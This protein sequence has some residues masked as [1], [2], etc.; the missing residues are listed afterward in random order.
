MCFNG[1]LSHPRGYNISMRQWLWHSL[2]RKRQAH[3][4]CRCCVLISWLFMTA[5]ADNNKYCPALLYTTKETSEGE[6]RV[7]LFREEASLRAGKNNFLP[8]LFCWN[9]NG[10]PSSKK[11]E[12][13]TLFSKSER[14]SVIRVVLRARKKTFHVYFTFRLGENHPQDYLKRRFHG[15]FRGKKT[16]R[17]HKGINPNLPHFFST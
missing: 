13:A 5:K 1:L 17:G 9:A 12:E 8:R 2:P 15:N 16:R 6:K 3:C 7:A 14:K 10:L 11:E 4:Y